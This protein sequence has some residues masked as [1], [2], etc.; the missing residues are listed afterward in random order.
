MLQ[1][2]DVSS[3]NLSTQLCV[4]SEQLLISSPNPVMN[5]WHWGG[6]DTAR[7]AYLVTRYQRPSFVR[8]RSGRYS[9]RRHHST[10]LRPKPLT[11]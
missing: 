2:I 1:P 6:L 7:N 3:K 5:P 9:A 8:Q 10:R 11:E 4:P